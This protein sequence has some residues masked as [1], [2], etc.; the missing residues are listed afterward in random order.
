MKRHIINNNRLYIEEGIDLMIV[1][2]RNNYGICFFT[3]TDR[4]FTGRKAKAHRHTPF[5]NTKYVELPI[6]FNGSVVAG[7]FFLYGDERI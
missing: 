1:T 7:D 6:D 4:A 3:N 2:Q 5:N